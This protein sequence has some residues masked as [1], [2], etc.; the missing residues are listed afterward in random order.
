M[1]KVY[2][3]GANGFI[4]HNLVNYLSRNNY[5]VVALLRKGSI[6]Y[7]DLKRNVHVVV[8]DLTDKKSLQK[9]TPERSI[10]INLAANP[11]HPTLSYKVNVEGTKNLLNI[12]KSKKIR[13]FIQI[14]SQAT[15][16]KKKEVYAKTKNESDKL[17]EKSNLK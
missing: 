12:C 14:S 4:G 13:L 7:F 11:Y 6:P 15:K 9:A 3:T 1:K 17:V 5:D 10:V 2:I 8:G 16:I